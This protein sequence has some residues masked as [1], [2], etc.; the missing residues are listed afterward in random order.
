[1]IVKHTNDIM[2]NVV[3]LNVVI[4]ISVNIGGLRNLICTIRVLVLT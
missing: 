1:M 4:P 2:F 3:P